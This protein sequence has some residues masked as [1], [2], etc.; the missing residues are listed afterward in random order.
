MLKFLFWGEKP[1]FRKK[2]PRQGYRLFQHLYPIADNI[3][4][5][6]SKV[7]IAR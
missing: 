1:H 4:P 6:S 2:K 5:L 7:K 3:G